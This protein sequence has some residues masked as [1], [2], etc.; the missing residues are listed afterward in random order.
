M[1]GDGDVR[2]FYVLEEGSMGG[3]TPR[4]QEAER[5]RQR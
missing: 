3:M 5:G 1:L 4:A 2:T